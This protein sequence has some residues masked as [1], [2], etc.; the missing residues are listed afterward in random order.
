MSGNRKPHAPSCFE[1]SFED[2]VNIFKDIQPAQKMTP[3]KQQLKK[4]VIGAAGLACL[5]KDGD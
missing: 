3:W 5:T 1:H 2:S 4:P